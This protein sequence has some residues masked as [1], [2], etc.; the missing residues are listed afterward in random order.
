VQSGETKYGKP[1]IDWVV[2]HETSLD[3]AAKCVLLSFDATMRSNL[4]V[5][6]P[7]D[8]LCYRIGDLSVRMRRRFEAGDAYFDALSAQWSE[9]TR[10]AFRR[11][12]DLCWT[13]D[14]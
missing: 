5:G 1:I 12:P 7:I 11:L 6:M 9:S 4:S 2:T 8:L 13:T 3:D 14:P 10:A